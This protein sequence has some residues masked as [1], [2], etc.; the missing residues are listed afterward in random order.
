MERL[1]TQRKPTLPGKISSEE[2]LISLKINQDVSLWEAKQKRPL[3]K[4]SKKRRKI[5]TFS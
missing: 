4:L 5:K 3:I 2:F 1:P